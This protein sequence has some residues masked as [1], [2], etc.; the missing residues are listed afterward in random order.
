[1]LR[2]KTKTTSPAAA[3]G[4]GSA[5]EWEMRPGGMLVQKRSPDSENLPPPP[6]I[7]VRVKYGSIYHEIS[8]SSQAT[9]G[10][11]KKM[12]TGP[13]GMHHED[14][15][16]LFKDKERDSKA[17]LDIS[18]V[19]DKSKIVLIE[20]PIS[21]EKR[22]VEMR[23][24]AKMEKAAKAISEISLEVDRLAG[25]V[26]ALESVISRGGKVAERSVINVIESLMTQLVKLDGIVAEG[27]VKVQRKT[28][29]ARVQKYVETLDVL[30]LKNSV[31]TSNGN[32]TPIA[33]GD[34]PVLTPK[35]QV[36]P[37]RHSA[38]GPVVITTQWET[39]DPAPAPLLDPFSTVTSTSG[40][41]HPRVSWDLLS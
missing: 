3:N 23:K 9:F 37:S 13:T 20:D 6:N 39:F 15:K 19:K 24:N 26:S 17:F 1:M 29:V 30:K 27:D 14:Q 7:R 32:H 38:S 8:I 5:N 4:G 22:Y 2:M 33:R 28:Q 11:L 18:G 10:E 31:P 35:H 16:L 21:K 41:A 40:S 12:L 25:Q 36:E 34:S